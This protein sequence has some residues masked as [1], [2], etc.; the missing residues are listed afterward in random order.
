MG[1]WLD[2]LFEDFC[3]YLNGK[4]N[5]SKTKPSEWTDTIWKF[6]S[7]KNRTES[8]PYIE[9]REHMRVDYMWR[10]DPS[11]YSVYDI[12][13]AVEHEGEERKVD[14]LVNEEIQHLTDLKAR[15]R[16]GIFYPA[17]G[18]EKELI[19]K[20]QK[21]IKAQSMTSPLEKYLIILGYTTRK[22]G[23][24]AILFRGF[25]FDEKGDL[26]KR[27][28]YIIFQAIEKKT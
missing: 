27:K 16:I 13:L 8:I 1:V 23:K 25:F 19:E 9:I 14:I 22:A 7:E 18:D 21:R 5:W 3:Q 4:L 12:E 26:E 10:Y 6:F 20:I 11:R 17:Q 28:Q 15:N 2:S 24:R